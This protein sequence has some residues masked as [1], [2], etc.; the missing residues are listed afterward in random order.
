MKNGWDKKNIK[1]IESAISAWYLVL[2]YVWQVQE[3]FWLVQF[4]V[5]VQVP[6]WKTQC[7][8]YNICLVAR[9]EVRLQAPK[10][11]WLA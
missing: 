11:S 6:E 7:V 5:C 10:Q 2:K 8:N 3:M 1:N 9:S 4:E